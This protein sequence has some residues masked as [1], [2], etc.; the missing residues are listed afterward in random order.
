MSGTLCGILDAYVYETANQ[1]RA[2]GPFKVIFEFFERMV[3]VGN[4]ARVALQWGNGGS[5]TD[6]MDGAAPF[7]ENAFFVYKL[8]A[9]ASSLRSTDLYVL[10][11]WAYSDAWG[12][13][14]GN[15]CKFDNSTTGD[16]VAIQMAFRED[17][18]NPWAGTTNNDGSDTKAA[19]VWTAGGSVL[20]VLDRC[21]SDTA[22]GTPGACVTNKENMLYLCN[23]NYDHGRT[24]C[25]GD[26]DGFVI[27]TSE[28]G[29]LGSPSNYFMTYGGVYVP[30]AGMTITNPYLMVAEH[31]SAT[32]QLAA[33]GTV[34]G[35]YNASTYYEGGCLN[36]IPTDK[37]QT[38]ALQSFYVLHNLA[39]QPNMQIAGG[40]FDRMP[41]LVVAY[42]GSTKGLIGQIYPT[43]LSSVY[44]LPMET[45]N[46]AKTVAYL[47][48]TDIDGQ[49]FAIPWDGG[50][51]P[52]VNTTT[53][54]WRVL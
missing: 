15:P 30:R 33:P 13:S 42:E 48:T 22:V 36:N 32:V 39:F 10:I 1:Q 27:F 54:T 23:V 2:F 25:V 24:H 38:F 5:G 43:I 7:G 17:G 6:W 9:S 34:V 16:G 53:R 19:T 49:Q 47:G 14:P 8:L 11:Q 50:D 29:N 52:G 31:T 21:C 4:A 51:A 41:I 40:E 35:T 12:A 37:V 20:H 44:G 26:A 3:A 46:A 28:T 18:G 45:T